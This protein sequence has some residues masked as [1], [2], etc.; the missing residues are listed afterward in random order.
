MGYPADAA[1]TRSLGLRDMTE[2]AGRIFVGKCTDRTVG[3]DSVS[4]VS[5]TTYY[6]A[7]I[8]PIKGVETGTI[9]FRVPGTPD[10]PLIPYLPVI[11]PGDVRLLALYPESPAGFATPMGLDQG[12]FV[13]E[14]GEDGV[15]R[16]ANGR[17]NRGLLRDVPGSALANEDLEPTDRGP[18]ELRKL[19]SM[20]DR[21]LVQTTP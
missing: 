4:G 15:V 8:T 9:L 13:L 1:R 12:C 20:L 19:L 5:F 10:R 11:E 2:R 16:A 14:T 21:L 17:R 18:L 7:I 3:V 6:F